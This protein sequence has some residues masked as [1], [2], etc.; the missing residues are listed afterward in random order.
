MS[1]T[2]QQ[3]GSEDVPGEAEMRRALVEYENSLAEIASL[4]GHIRHDIN[5]ALTGLLGQT[6][7]LLREDLSDAARRRLQ[8]IEELGTRI[9]DRVAELRVAEDPRSDFAQDAKS[10]QDSPSRH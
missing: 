7:L 5:N 3:T 1:E 10:E 8:V 9:R 2:E 6:H 4:A